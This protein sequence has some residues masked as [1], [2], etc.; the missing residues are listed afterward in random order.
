MIPFF[1]S[2]LNGPGPVAQPATSKETMTATYFMTQCQ[3]SKRNMVNI[4]RVAL[5]I[6]DKKSA[7][8][9]NFLN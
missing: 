3:S 8:L 1:F 4:A 6:L 9:R 5:N 7:G 2:A